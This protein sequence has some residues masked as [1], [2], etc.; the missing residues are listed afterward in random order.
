MEHY[1]RIW[2]FNWHDTPEPEPEEN[3][4]SEND[5]YK[6]DWENYQCQIYRLFV[7]ISSYLSNIGSN[8][9]E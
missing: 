1:Q 2:I 4:L 6:M 7:N 8:K 5:F 3:N 9:T